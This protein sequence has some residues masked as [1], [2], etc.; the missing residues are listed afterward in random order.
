MEAK[1]DESCSQAVC[2][3]VSFERSIHFKGVFL[4][5]QEVV[6]EYLDKKHDK[7]V[8]PEDLEKPQDQVSTYLCTMSAKNPARPQNMCCI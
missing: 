4:E 3:F 2:R 6:Q 8:P 5:V 7:E 1:I